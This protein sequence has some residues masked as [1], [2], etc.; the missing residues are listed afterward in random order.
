MLFVF[1]FRSCDGHWWEFG[2]FMASMQAVWRRRLRGIRRS[3]VSIT[4]Q[5]WSTNITQYVR[6]LR[7]SEGVDSQHWNHNLLSSCL[8][9]DVFSCA[10]CGLVDKPQ[11][12]MQLEVFL[13]CPSSVPWTVKVKVRFTCQIGRCLLFFFKDLFWEIIIIFSSLCFKR[14]RKPHLFL[15]GV[16]F[17]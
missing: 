11:R 3:T 5:F 7:W 1:S 9:R 13:S 16:N 8:S 12:K 2:V 17:F 14:G 10:E 4:L 15:Q 6:F